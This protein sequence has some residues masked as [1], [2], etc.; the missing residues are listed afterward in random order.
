MAT[1]AAKPLP[2]HHQSGKSSRK[3]GD[4]RDETFG[5]SPHESRPE[6]AVELSTD[7]TEADDAD[8]DVLEAAA[9]VC[10]PPHSSSNTFAARV[11]LLAW[12]STSTASIGDCARRCATAASH[13]SDIS[14]AYGRISL[15]A[16][17]GSS[18]EKHGELQVGKLAG[19][20]A[21]SSLKITAEEKKSDGELMLLL[22]EQG[23]GVL[24][25]GGAP[26]RSGEVVREEIMQLGVAHGFAKGHEG[27]FLPKGQVEH[28][29]SLRV[30]RG[31]EGRLSQ[32]RGVW[33]CQTAIRPQVLTYGRSGLKLCIRAAGE[34]GARGDESW[35]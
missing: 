6:E 22:R 33:G 12:L 34:H 8:K 3:A 1:W 30:L 16:V 24:Q 31:A 32:N 20:H 11:R 2:P 9:V 29:A 27:S 23:E 17:E 7:P 15:V 35:P 26:T 25:C 10:T 21:H 19:A 14:R 28:C 18:S 13:T 4:C 5:D